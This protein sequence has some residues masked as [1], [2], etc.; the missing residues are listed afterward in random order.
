MNGHSTESRLAI[1]NSLFRGT[2][3]TSP[4]NSGLGFMPAFR[5]EQTGCVYPSCFSDGHRAPVHVYDGLPDGLVVERDGMGKPRS[6]KVSVTSGFLRG[7][8]FYTRAEAAR[9]SNQKEAFVIG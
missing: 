3:G 4:V 7:N 8:F 5:D 6:V 1:E 2:G 9:L